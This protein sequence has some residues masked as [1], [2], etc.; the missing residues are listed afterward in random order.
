M[1]HSHQ[2]PQP[3]Q[4]RL[5]SLCLNQLH[6]HPPPES[7]FSSSQTLYKTKIPL[8]LI[9]SPTS[10]TPTSTHKTSFFGPKIVSSSPHQQHFYF[11]EPHSPSL[12]CCFN[13]SSRRWPAFKL[14]CTSMDPQVDFSSSLHSPSEIIV[15]LFISLTLVPS[16][17]IV[18][19]MVSKYNLDHSL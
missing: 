11:H 13:V 14:G 12:R 16:S 19:S 1:S 6:E 15:S 8:C 9:H 10:T 2:H 18:S 3:Q 17:I 5:L 4:R 7:S